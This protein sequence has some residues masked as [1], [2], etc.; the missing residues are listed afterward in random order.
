LVQGSDGYLVAKLAKCSRQ[1]L[2][3]FLL[4]SG[5]NFG[6]F[7]EEAYAFMQD[8]PNYTTEPMSNGPDS[9][10]LAQARQQ[11]PKHDLKMTAFLG[12]GSV[13]CLVQHP[14]HVFI[15]FRGATAMVLFR[16]FLLARTGS[17]PRG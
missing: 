8:L 17:H 2:G 12:R 4:F 16:A 10:L 9:G 14:A 6:T 1:H 13:C 3:T 7:F 5:M 11:T 15:A